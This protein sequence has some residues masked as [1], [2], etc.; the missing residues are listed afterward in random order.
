LLGIPVGVV[1]YNPFGDL[2]TMLYTEE[3]IV[4][5]GS[6]IAVSYGARAKGV[7]RSMKGKEAKQACP[8]VVLVQVPTKHGKADLTIYR[9][10]GENVVKLINQHLTK[11]I[12]EKAS[13]DEV[14][15]DITEEV[16]A[17]M[18]GLLS[19]DN[20]VSASYNFNINNHNTN[21]NFAENIET[22]DN[23][24]NIANNINEVK[25]SKIET[26]DDIIKRASLS[27]IAG[28]DIEE[29][30]LSKTDIRQGHIGTVFSSSFIIN[31]NNNNNSSS[32]TKVD[33]TKDEKNEKVSI[34]TTANIETAVS[35][36]I[37]NSFNDTLL[38][39]ND[40]YNSYNSF[41]QRILESFCNHSKYTNNNNHS[42]NNNNNMQTSINLN[43]LPNYDKRLLIGAAIIAEMREIIR[44]KLSFTSSGGIAH[45][46]ICA[47]IASG[48]HKPNKQTI[49]PSSRVKSLMCN[50]PISRIPGLGI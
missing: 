27:L 25:T 7:K 40:D 24:N 15:L 47:K 2:K 46:K 10:A 38:V 48:M 14:Y 12:I 37:N 19:I 9:T 43:I 49:V 11:S 28:E 41:K 26:F 23:N 18:N 1:Q 22:L 21:D 5:S 13:I 35:N 39:D 29:L 50:L 42:N 33:R 17:R 3:R 32:A 44:N 20:T 45:N 4:N 16:N 34:T 36:T 31:N 6:L 30:K 8:E